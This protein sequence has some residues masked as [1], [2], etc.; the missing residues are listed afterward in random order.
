[1]TTLALTA[2]MIPMSLG[3]GEGGQFRALLGVAVIGGVLT[4][5]LLTLLVIPTICDILDRAR[6][7]V[8]GRQGYR[9]KQMP[10][11]HRSRAGR[12]LGQTGGD[13][14]ASTGV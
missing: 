9:P 5:T 4:S 2:G 11:E 8:A 7:R 12:V 13:R 14:S 6:S 3:S 1:M 10:A